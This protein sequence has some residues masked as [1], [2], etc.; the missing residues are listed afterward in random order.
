M[1]IRIVLT[2]YRQ[3]I[4]NLSN[5]LVQVILFFC[6]ECSYVILILNS[7]LLTIF[8][9][10]LADV[11]ATEGFE[12]SSFGRQYKN[13]RI[14]MNEYKVTTSTGVEY[15]YADNYYTGQVPEYGRVAYFQ[16]DTLICHTVTNVISIE[17]NTVLDSGT[18]RSPQYF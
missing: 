14:N 17:P 12:L 8:W 16:R 10:I 9:S 18:L 1:G 4:R 13:R 11:Q 3:F 15:V 2:S 5:N 7:L 6:R